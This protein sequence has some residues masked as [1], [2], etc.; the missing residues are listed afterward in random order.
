MNKMPKK[1]QKERMMQIKKIVILLSF[2]FTRINLIAFPENVTNL[3]ITAESKIDI[4]C[5][6]L[7]SKIDDINSLVQT[8]FDGTFT[9]LASI[10]ATEQSDFIGT[11]SLINHALQ[12]E[13][14]AESKLDICCFSINS[15]IDI[16]SSEISETFTVYN[17]L[18]E[19]GATIESKLDACCSL[20]DCNPI[21][22]FLTP[23]GTSITQPGV[24]CLAHDVVFN[25]SGGIAIRSN[26][27]VLDL[28]NHTITGPSIASA[29]LI[30]QNT[31]QVTVKNGTIINADNGI[32]VEFSTR[33]INVRDITISGG[34]IGFVA[35]QG[36]VANVH[37]QNINCQN[38]L[39]AGFEFTQPTNCTF[40]DCSALNGLAGSIGFW[41]NDTATSV[42]G[43]ASFINCI[44][45]NNSVGFSI[46]DVRNTFFDSCSAF[47]N[48]T[49]GFF[50]R[51]IQN[52][53]ENL[54]FLNCISEKCDLGFYIRSD[55][56]P[57]LNTY[58]KNCQ[59][60]HNNSFGFAMVD[61]AGVITHCIASHNNGVG[62]NLFPGLV[63]YAWAARNCIASCNVKGFDEGEQGLTFYNNEASHN[64]TNY[65]IFGPP[66]S[67]E[68]KLFSDPVN[69][70]GDNLASSLP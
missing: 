44:S 58:I 51:K 26:N 24:Y 32:R 64:T 18:F 39:T 6:T 40:E 2:L 13:L 56:F 7:N 50:Y 37:L 20:L 1:V 35:Q 9:V 69:G 55:A 49:E 25:S 38:Y 54:I 8:D 67:A 4:C 30:G 41:M 27:V 29:I 57:R 43:S 21:P 61:A 66:F 48:S 45:S 59:A 3:V 47:N 14:T 33:N 22:L 53:P 52:A 28:N 10:L 68:I 60:N 65:T 70:R 16:L 42:D 34:N 63:A 17:A 11:N 19:Q 12:Q 46:I 36:P 5:A 15:K 23:S 31:E 62:F